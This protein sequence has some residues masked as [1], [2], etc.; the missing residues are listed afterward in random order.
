MNKDVF[1]ANNKEQTEL[2]TD[3]FGLTILAHLDASEEK[4][5]GVQ[6]KVK[7][8]NFNYQVNRIKIP[9]V[10]DQFF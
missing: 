10:P 1:Y 7:L 5:T 4:T 6:E 2:L 8:I 9:G 3:P